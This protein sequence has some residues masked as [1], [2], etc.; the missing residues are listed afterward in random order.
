MSTHTPGYPSDLG[1]LFRAIKANCPSYDYSIVR[2]AMAIV[3]LNHNH[4]GQ[5]SWEYAAMSRLTSVC[6]V[7]DG[8]WREIEDSDDFNDLTIETMTEA[9]GEL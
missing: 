1:D 7:K 2:V 9:E 3:W 8:L 4:R 6:D 5:G